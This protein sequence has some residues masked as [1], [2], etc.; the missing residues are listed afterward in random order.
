MSSPLFDLGAEP[1]AQALPPIEAADRA[2][3]R[4]SG[5]VYCIPCDMVPEPAHSDPVWLRAVYRVLEVTFAA[6]VLALSLPLLLLAALLI[7][8]ESPG[9]AL[10]KHT[11]VGRSRRV[12]GAELKGRTDVVAPDGQFEDDRWYFVPTTFRLIKFRSMYID[13]W[14]RFPEMFD[15]KYASHDEFLNALQKTKDDPRITRVGAV[16][17]KLTIDE[18]PNMWSVITGDIRLVGPRP[19]GLPFMPYYLPHEMVKF[20][21]APGVTGYQQT[22]GRANLTKGQ[23]I[24]CDLQY[25]HERCVAVDLRVVALTVWMV[26]LRR[27]AF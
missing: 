18:L 2:T 8:A 21:V 7:R 22:R 15:V 16:L 10:F 25:V 27:G 20:T 1:D 14:Q 12:L 11:R 19:E 17:R 26:L 5:P 23:T 13:A 24:E 4:V 9:P 6:V 3:L